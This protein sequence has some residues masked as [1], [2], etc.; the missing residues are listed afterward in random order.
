MIKEQILVLLSVQQTAEA[1]Q[2][3]QLHML[4]WSPDGSCSKLSTL[5]SVINNV[6]NIQMRT[7][8]N[9]IVVHCRCG[10]VYIVYII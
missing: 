4:N 8:N 5:T 6:V 3:V 10:S 2:V 1:H 7:G 9:P